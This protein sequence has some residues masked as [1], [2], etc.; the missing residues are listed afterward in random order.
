MISLNS[1]SIVLCFKLSVIYYRILIVTGKHYWNLELD[2]IRS[3]CIN[4][5]MNIM[6]CLLIATLFNAN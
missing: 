4:S 1:I 2:V 5:G 3:A 6:Y